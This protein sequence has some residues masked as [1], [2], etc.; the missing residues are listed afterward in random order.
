[1]LASAK[2]P[3]AYAGAE[4]ASLADSTLSQAVHTRLPLPARP[5]APGQHAQKLCYSCTVSAAQP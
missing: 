4:R 1:M 5:P 2:K 3:S